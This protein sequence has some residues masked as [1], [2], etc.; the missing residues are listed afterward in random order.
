MTYQIL[1][2]SGVIFSGTEEE[3]EELLE[4]NFVKVLLQDEVDI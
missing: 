1:D 4:D 3:I 2:D